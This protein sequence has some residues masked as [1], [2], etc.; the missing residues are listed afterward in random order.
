MKRHVETSLKIVMVKHINL[1]K[2]KN[3]PSLT[4]LIIYL[5]LEASTR[6]R[7]CRWTRSGGREWRGRWWRR[8]WWRSWNTW[9]R[10]NRL[11]ISWKNERNI[12]VSSDEFIRIFC[13]NWLFP[14]SF[15]SNSAFHSFEEKLDW[16]FAE[17]DKLWWRET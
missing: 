11:T 15:S 5:S 6:N 3:N 1:K 14:K 13:L 8:R 12:K 7:V 2:F 17:F 4:R 16:S 10:R 9:R